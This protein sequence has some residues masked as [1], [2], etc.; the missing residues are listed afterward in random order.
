[1]ENVAFNYNENIEMELPGNNTS[2]DKHK[3]KE[4]KCI[5]K[6]TYYC[7]VSKCCN[8]ETKTEGSWHKIKTKFLLL[9]LF[10]FVIWAILYF[11]LLHN[12]LI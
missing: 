9:F 8:N 4:S 10:G 5:D 2:D 3:T 7:D 1:M 6:A 11:C 12:D